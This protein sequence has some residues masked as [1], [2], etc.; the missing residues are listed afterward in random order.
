MKP[1]APGV[2]GN[3]VRWSTWH[4]PHLTGGCNAFWR[5]QAHFQAP[6]PR[7]TEELPVNRLGTPLAVRPDVLHNA[8]IDKHFRRGHCLLHSAFILPLSP[9]FLPRTPRPWTVLSR[10]CPGYRP[11]CTR[12]GSH[13]ALCLQACASLFSLCD[14]TLRMLLYKRG[15]AA[16]AADATVSGA[17]GSAPSPPRPG[18]QPASA[19]PPAA[20]GATAVSN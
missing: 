8:L 16:G 12:C 20:V 11:V 18:R 9:F 5:P 1:I 7:R 14:C 15:I 6:S 2:D 19:G 10:C 13:N 4:V 17:D 3:G